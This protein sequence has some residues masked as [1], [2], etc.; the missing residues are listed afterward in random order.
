MVDAKAR[1]G[2]SPRGTLHPG[3]DP[4]QGQLGV[5]EQVLRRV[6]LGTVA[7]GSI[8]EID[9]CS[10]RTGRT[11]TAGGAAI[12]CDRLD[13]PI[14]LRLA[15]RRS[16]EQRRS[17]SAYSRNRTMYEVCGESDLAMARGSSGTE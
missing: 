7:S 3:V 8:A 2:V 11:R 13:Y 5:L 17:T 4:V 1:P 14:E 12:R 15:V 10:C 16:W 9:A 6:F